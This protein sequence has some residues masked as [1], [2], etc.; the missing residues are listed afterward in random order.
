MSMKVFTVVALVVALVLMGR[1]ILSLRSSQ[2]DVR[3]KRGAAEEKLMKSQAEYDT[4]QSELNYLANPLNFEKELRSRL[5]FK[6]PS[7]KMI[8]V[9]PSSA[10]TSTATSTRE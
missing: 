6:K 5:N 9:V 2:E 7:E 4:L 1:Q 8:I 3:A 10:P